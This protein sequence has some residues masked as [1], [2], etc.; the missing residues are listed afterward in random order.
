MSI[1]MMTNDEGDD[2]NAHDDNYDDVTGDD[3]D[4]T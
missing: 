1:G 3:D 2:C 4:D